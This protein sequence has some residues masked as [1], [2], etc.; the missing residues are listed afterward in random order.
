MPFQDSVTI[1]WKS[2]GFLNTDN[3]VDTGLEWHEGKYMMTELSLWVNCPFKAGG[4]FCCWSFCYLWNIAP[5]EMSI[6]AVYNKI[7]FCSIMFWQIW[8]EWVGMEGEG[9]K[10]GDE[11]WES[12]VSPGPGCWL[13]NCGVF[14][15]SIWCRVWRWGFILVMLL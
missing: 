5:G 15:L 6:W 8:T 10:G 12:M 14:T 11:G 3:T 1:E 2:V 4:H 9:E 13:H 7:R